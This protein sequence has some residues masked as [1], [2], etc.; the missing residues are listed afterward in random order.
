[1]TYLKA[2]HHQKK[3]FWRLA[4]KWRTAQTDIHLANL[5]VLENGAVFL[6]FA[7]LRR[8]KV[9]D[10]LPICGYHLYALPLSRLADPHVE[11]DSIPRIELRLYPSH[12]GYQGYPFQRAIQAH[13][14]THY[15]KVPRGNAYSLEVV[16]NHS[17]N[18][19]G[20]GLGS[21]LLKHALLQAD[22]LCVTHGIILTH[23]FGEIIPYD[24]LRL[25]D[26][27]RFY[28]KN[29]FKRTACYIYLPL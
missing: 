22:Q 4:R 17:E 6:E 24:R 28:K 9:A 19:D 5:L 7:L 14:A 3:Q 11:L 15:G 12:W 25:K 1:M 27:Q 18:C 29:G 23:A 16:D 8:P 26:I 20:M 13:L 2:T 21:H 10:T